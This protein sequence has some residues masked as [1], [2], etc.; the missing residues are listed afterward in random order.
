MTLPVPAVGYEP[1]TTGL[2]ILLAMY[3]AF[4]SLDMA[5]RV[6]SADPVVVRGWMIGGAF[7]MG[8][9]I[10][11]MHFE[12]M[13]AHS[14]PFATGYDPGLS[15]LSLLLSIATSGWALWSSSR[16][17]WLRRVWLLPAPGMA[18]GLLAMHYTG[19]AAIRVTP[20]VVWNVPWL[21]ASIV[22][23]LATGLLTFLVTPWFRGRRRA[24]YGWRQFGASILLGVVLSATHF[25]GIQAQSYPEGTVCL[26]TDGLGGSSLAILIG[27]ASAIVLTSTWLTSRLDARHQQRAAHLSQSLQRADAQLQRVAEVDGLTG[28]AN[29]LVL[30]DRLTRAVHRA[31]ERQR[32]V[33]L[34][35]IDLDGFKPINDSFGHHFGD[36]LL[37]AV[38]R[39]LQDVGRRGDT[40]AR[41]GGDEFV[42]LIN[43][44]PDAS[45]AA[46][47]AARVR[48]ALHRPFEVEGREVHLSCSI[49]VVLYPDHGP[50]GKLIARADAAMTAAKH[51][52]GNALC[53][54]EEHME[55]DAQRSVDLQRDLRRAMDTHEGLSLHY[56]PKIDGHTGQVTGAEA[57]LRWQHPQLGAIS[58][59]EFIP[60]AERFGLIAR[61]GQWVIDD[62]CRQVHDWMSKGLRMRVAINLS[63]H[64]LRQADLAEQVQ[65]AL[66]RHQVPP[67]LITFEV[68][69][70]AA[71]EDPQASLRI[72]ERLAQIRVSLSIDDFGTGYSSLSYL[73]KLPARQLKI[74]RSF[75]QDL[76]REEDAR[77]IVKAVIK[78]SHALGLEVVAEGVETRAQQDILKDLGCD[79]LQ[80]FLYA[81]PMSASKLELWALGEESDR[82]TG[83]AGQGVETGMRPN[84]S[85]SLFNPDEPAGDAGAASRPPDQV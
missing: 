51:A 45:S 46:L 7:I 8:L 60:I 37:C 71:M 31:E 35:Y 44:N 38:G 68:T 19:M 22:L 55:H 32:R 61:L 78:L 27:L 13:L 17:D 30:E 84:F 29:R 85:D 73:R 26:S 76:E 20:G 83:D 58:P 59:V 67:E 14:L 47:V 25:A 64:Q 34:L 53:F 3:T 9:G 43:G 42:I 63:V 2:A 48:D 54:Y 57:L 56:Q 12:G 4:V 15:A 33:A 41:I 24:L 18:V 16:D 49:G 21:V 72:F 62:A 5:K 65:E 6:R 81:K 82:P 28:L 40:V 69:E 79:Q 10:W 52:G 66:D 75:V 36:N 74:D 39:R 70:S 11:S 50:K 80:G 1:L 77:S 23:A